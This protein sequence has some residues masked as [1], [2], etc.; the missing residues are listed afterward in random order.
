MKQ[1][2]WWHFWNPMSGLAGGIVGGA[3]IA[4]LV[5]VLLEYHDDIVA[6]SASIFR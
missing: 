1:V 3:V 5:I 4:I 6:L 2:P